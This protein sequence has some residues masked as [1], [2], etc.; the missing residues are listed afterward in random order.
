MDLKFVSIAR[1]LAEGQVSLSVSVKILTVF[2]FTYTNRSL[3][4]SGPGIHDLSIFGINDDPEATWELPG[5]MTVPELHVEV[6]RKFFEG[7]FNNS[8]VLLMYMFNAKKCKGEFAFLKH[9]DPRCLAE[10]LPYVDMGSELD[11]FVRKVRI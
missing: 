1:G 8:P 2:Y 10:V 5:K 9:Y 11:L 4:R 3:F 7:R 6:Y